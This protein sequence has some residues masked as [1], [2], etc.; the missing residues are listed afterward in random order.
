MESKYELI[1]GY[2]VKI[3]TE[4]IVRQTTM[5]VSEMEN[6][7]SYLNSQI[8][9]LEERKTAVEAELLIIKQLMG[10]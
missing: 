10:E 7:I 3:E 5:S 6:Q 8:A 9:E 4:T 2:P 1:D